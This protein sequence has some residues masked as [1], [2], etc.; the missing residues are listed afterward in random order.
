MYGAAITRQPH[1]FT[2]HR[3]IL[4][5]AARNCGMGHWVSRST[6]SVFS[7]EKGLISSSISLI[8]R[9]LPK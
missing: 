6:M 4:D 9:S 8:V 2:H 5:N 3:M 1:F 7:P